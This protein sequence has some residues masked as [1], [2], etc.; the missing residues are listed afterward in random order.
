MS[1]R[2]YEFNERKSMKRIE[3][4]DKENE[5]KRVEEDL[6]N[7]QEGGKEKIDK[8]YEEMQERAKLELEEAKLQLE[9]AEKNIIRVRSRRELLIEDSVRLNGKIEMLVASRDQT[10]KRLDKLELRIDY[11]IG[12]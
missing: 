1:K 9:E 5:L 8:L 4:A 6:D 7:F 10:V 2:Q 11:D 3:L 12:L